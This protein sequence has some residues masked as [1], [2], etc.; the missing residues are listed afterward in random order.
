VDTELGERSYEWKVRVEDLNKNLNLDAIFSRNLNMLASAVRNPR[1]EK[2]E[3]ERERER[4]EK[5]GEI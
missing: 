2:R 3:R 1:F 5:K 4:N